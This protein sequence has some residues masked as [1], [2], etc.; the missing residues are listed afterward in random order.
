MSHTTSTKS[1][2]APAPAAAQDTGVSFVQIIE[3]YRSEP[4]NLNNLIEALV[5]RDRMLDMTH[6][7]RIKDYHFSDEE[8]QSTTAAGILDHLEGVTDAQICALLQ[9]DTGAL[10]NYQPVDRD[11]LRRI[12]Q[13]LCTQADQGKIHDLRSFYKYLFANH[14]D[15]VAA[16]AESVESDLLQ[17]C[18]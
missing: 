7:L 13:D 18:E 1:T 15:R 4:E 3:R 17:L 2:S 6:E 5:V 16:Y 14:P 8:F 11:S 12:Y 9:G 10:D